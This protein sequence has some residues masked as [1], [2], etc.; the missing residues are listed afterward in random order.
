[1]LLL[2]LLTSLFFVQIWQDIAGFTIRLE[3]IIILLVVGGTLAVVL[4]NGRISYLKSRLNAPIILWGMAFAFGVCI[5]L[6]SSSFPAE[7]KKDAVVNGVRLLLS[8]S[9]FFALYNFPVDAVTKMRTVLTTIIVISFLT[10]AVS[11]LQILYWEGWLPFTLPS[12]LLELKAGANLQRGREIFALYIGNTGSHTWANMLVIQVVVVWFAAWY[13]R[14][15]IWRTSFLLYG[16]LLVI[17]LIRISVRNS[18]LGLF[19]SLGLMFLILSIQSQYPI[20]RLVKPGLLFFLGIVLLAALFYFGA[21]YYFTQRIIHAIPQ[22]TGGQ[23]VVSRG[24]NVYG[25]LT[26][27]ETAVSIFKAHPILGSGFY[28]YE[29]LSD[30]FG[31]R[32][33]VHAHNSYLQTLAEL[34]MIGFIILGWLLWRIGLFLF[35][36]RKSLAMNKE[37]ALVWQITTTVFIYF[38]FTGLFANTFWSPANTAILMIFLGIL[39]SICVTKKPLPGS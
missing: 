1:M 11:L 28:T 23:V 21:E 24:S 5:T 8:L 2:A 17:I 29:S 12:V 4:L 14:R 7:V 32:K 15:F 30:V 18:I 38:L 19:I 16:F 36:T 3:D 25:R 27:M 22:F 20:N 10:T 34:G 6:L 9:L 37:A 26:Y 39:A 33:I 35:A 31:A 13:K